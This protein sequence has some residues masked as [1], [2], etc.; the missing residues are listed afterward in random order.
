MTSGDRDYFMW[1]AEQERA[2]AKRSQGAVR[3]RHEE[4]ASAYQM[5]VI[6]IDMGLTGEDEG[7]P[8]VAAPIEHIII[9]A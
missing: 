8:G 5:R 2:A 3:G 1:R 9:A 4:F 7:E 6:Y